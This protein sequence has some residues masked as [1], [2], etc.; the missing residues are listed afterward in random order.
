MYKVMLVD[1]DYPVLE[2][3]SETIKWETLGV[4]LQS[5]HENGASAFERAQQDMPDI[6]ITDIGMPKMNGIELTKK[7]KAKNPH[8]KVAILS[9]HSDFDFA[10]QAL[11]LQVQDYLVKDTF[12]P[13]DLYQ[14]IAKFKEDLD[15]ENQFS[16]KQ[17][18]MKEMLDR[19][20]ESV[21]ERF[22]RKTIGQHMVDEKEWNSEAASLGL[23]L[24]K[25]GYIVACAM[26][27]NFRQVKQQYSSEDTLS[28]ALN[29]VV[30]D[31]INHIGSGSN[32]VH[33]SHGPRELFIFLPYV[34]PFSNHSQQHLIEKI[35]RVQSVVKRALNITLTC[36]AGGAFTNL[37]GLKKE[38]SQL[39]NDRKISFYSEPGSIMG[40]SSIHK[41]KE[42]VF[43]RYDEAAS[44]IRELI[45]LRDQ[46]KI[47]PIVNKWIS[48]LE[49]QKF[50]P[51]LVKEWILKLL[52][53]LKVKLQALQ[54]FH[55]EH[56]VDCLHQ[57]LIEIGFINE[58]KAWMIDYFTSLLSL[59]HNVY[60]QT[61][62]R[63]ILDAFRYVSVNLEKKISL[64]EVASYLFLNPSY[65]SRLFK[66]EVGETF[67]EY[68]T[69]MKI[70]RAKELLEQTS[71]SVGKISERLGYDNQSY[72]IKLFKTYVGLTP[73][74][75]RGGKSKILA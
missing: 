35:R 15:A 11:K 12:D 25:N 13:D 36:I 68:V 50:P 62:R 67:V 10:Q 72:F 57:E 7:L 49:V 9:C 28:F 27:H 48:Y 18:K 22:I 23:E 61:R 6:L 63:E 21:K 4:T 20:R 3:L 24:G 58:L 31:A 51:D 65:F 26:V 42:D 8:L 52:L 37:A 60:D 66:K 1:D 29:N 5:I 71:E 69:K 74:E 46:G 43:T 54:F 45:L 70:N 55:S 41:Q 59:A 75:Y 33:F 38:L 17:A 47:V 16:L 32:G 53:D 2:L 56:Q 34:H 30:S 44:D 19:N 14:V 39:E 73:I 40:K 64:D